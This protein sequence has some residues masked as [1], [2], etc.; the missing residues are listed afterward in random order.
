MIKRIGGALAATLGALALMLGLAAT[1]AF[2]TVYGCPDAGWVCF[3]NYE[4]FNSAG[5]IHG[6]D[7]RVGYETCRV[8]PTSGT[9]VWT[10]GRVANAASSLLINNTGANSLPG[11]MQLFLYNSNNCT[12]AAGYFVIQFQSGDLVTDYWR[13]AN[14]GW[15]DQFES[16]RIIDAN[17]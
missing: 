14:W 4:S 11:T 7:L 10:N 16:F 17:P 8:L 12:S 2:A 1:P 13:L 9:A 15:N 3:Y 5:G 6:R